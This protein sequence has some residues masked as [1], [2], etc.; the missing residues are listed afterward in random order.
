MAGC[1]RKKVNMD[2]FFFCFKKKNELKPLAHSKTLRGDEDYNRKLIK[3]IIKKKHTHTQR[4]RTKDVM[5]MM[6]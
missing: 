1:T 6:Q 3:I 4:K 5:Y 2:I